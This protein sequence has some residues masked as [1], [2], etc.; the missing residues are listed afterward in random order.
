[1][2]HRLCCVFPIVAAALFS[3][4]PATASTPPGADELATHGAWSVFRYPRDPW[5]KCYVGSE[6]IRSQ[7]AHRI[8]VDVGAAD[9]SI[10]RRAGH[11]YRQRGDIVHQGTVIVGT[12]SFPYLFEPFSSSDEGHGE[13]SDDRMVQAMHAAEAEA[14][15]AEL[16][17]R[18]ESWRGVEVTDAF[19]LRGF[20]AAYQAASG[21]ICKARTPPAETRSAV[22]LLSVNVEGAG[23]TLG[24]WYAEVRLTGPFFRKGE[25]ETLVIRA[26]PRD[27]RERFGGYW[28]INAGLEFFR[29]D[30]LIGR[31]SFHFHTD[32]ADVCV[33]PE[34][35][36]LEIVVTSSTGGSGGRVDS[37][38]LFYDPRT[39]RVVAM[40]RGS[41]GDEIY[42]EMHELED[43]RFVPAWCVFRRHLASVESFA[44]EIMKETFF[45][46]HHYGTFKNDEAVRMIEMTEVFRRDPTLPDG[47]HV[48]YTDDVFSGYLDR[49]LRSG[50]DSPLQFQR[51][52]SSEFSVV[53]MRH[54]GYS[55][56]DAFQ[57]VF[58]KE[59]GDDL[60]TP[61]YHAGPD[62]RL[63]RY[64]LA[65]VSGFLDEETLR[66]HVCVWECDPWEWGEFA[67]VNFNLRMFEGVVDDSE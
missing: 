35:G 24:G 29:G 44:R 33:S 5:G 19:S 63:E 10:V 40:E 3:V 20:T 36:R 45:T 13:I 58:V 6:P 50:P 52:D 18:G 60:W 23:R 15:E 59:A 56:R 55:F 4:A 65:E 26:I 39:R 37:Y 32:L 31:E 7:G 43:G 49:I 1:M 51:L 41:H 38:F 48:G 64:K 25:R 47:E 9:I 12:R 21:R 66:M 57:M 17:V 2:T 14:A 11:G 30:A 42:E 61:I 22:E 34:S 46:R 54:T 16:L 27:V 53:D 28:F 8:M 62:N 67:D